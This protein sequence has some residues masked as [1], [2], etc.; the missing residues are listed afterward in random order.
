M[1]MRGKKREAA[2]VL[3]MT[4]QAGLGFR[5]IDHDGLL[6]KRDMHGRFAS[7]G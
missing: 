7:S 1:E 5:T 6:K 3:R 2:D 4:R